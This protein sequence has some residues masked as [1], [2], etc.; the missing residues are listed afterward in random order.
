MHLLQQFYLLEI[1]YLQNL[2]RTWF[3]LNHEMQLRSISKGKQAN[4]FNAPSIYNKYFIVVILC[5]GCSNNYYEKN[6][7]SM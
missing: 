2:C 7:I 5:Y 3:V 1:S 6:P 4:D